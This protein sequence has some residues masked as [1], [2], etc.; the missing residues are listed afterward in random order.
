MSINTFPNHLCFYHRFLLWHFF[1]LLVCFFVFKLMLFLFWEARLCFC[2]IYIYIYIYIYCVCVCF[3]S[4]KELKI[5][6][7]I[8]VKWIFL[9]FFNF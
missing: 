4:N 9:L 6:L 8:T 3:V 5:S 7:F 2:N 1:E